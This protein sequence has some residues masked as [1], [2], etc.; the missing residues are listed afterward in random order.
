MVI[1]SNNINKMNNNLWP[2]LTEHTQD[3]TTYDVG[4]P[5]TGFGQ[6]HKYGGA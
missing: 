6:A 3:T 5:S 2:S 1:I 4:H